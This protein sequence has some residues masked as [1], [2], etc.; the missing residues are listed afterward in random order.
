MP[1][2]V[3]I[4]AF[5]FGI[6]LLVAIHEF[7]HFWV[8]RRLGIKILRFSIG[9]GKPLWG[10]TDKYGTE[11]VISALPLGGYVQMLDEKNGPVDEAQLPL[12]FNR[13][14]VWKR[15]A[16]VIAGPLFNIL[17]AIV[18]YWLMFV[19]G[20][21]G[22]VPIIGE[23]Q[24]GSVAAVADLRSGQEIVAVNGKKTPDWRAVKVSLFSILGEDK[25]IKVDLQDRQTKRSL[26][27]ELIVADLLADPSENANF[28]PV[29][30][31]GISPYFPM[32]TAT[33]G[34]VL[35]NQPAD[36][37]G[38]QVGDKIIRA[39]GQNIKDWKDFLNYIKDRP[40]QAVRLQIKRNGALHELEI[41]P[42]EQLISGKKYGYIGVSSL[43]ITWP[44][45][46]IRDNS[47]SL[48]AAWVPAVVETKTMFVLTLKTLTKMLTGQFSVR[49]IS[50]PIGIATGAG[51]SAM[52]GLPYYLGFLAL[53]SVSLAVLNILP[54]PMLDGGHLL[55]YVLEIILG[56]PLPQWVEEMGMRLGLLLLFGLLV[57]AI[58]NDV[59][60]LF[61]V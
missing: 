45:G 13:Q 17:F 42:E 56:R 8:A 51:Q 37:A 50:G 28:D 26:Q 5:V 57:I 61:A 52:F 54:I 14:S 21:T 40:Q 59:R 6:S 39:D 19:V 12:A 43:P 23:V 2:L 22:V 41:T 44:E 60:R 53:V 46:M 29:Q 48:L 36:K 7:G 15:I 34:Q 11:Y 33:I 1:F 47:Y 27:R 35:P 31:L 10:K 25:P 18:A 30:Q 49:N 16:V 38:L 20:I 3:T 9:F 4:I 55:Y 24:P 58:T 32:P